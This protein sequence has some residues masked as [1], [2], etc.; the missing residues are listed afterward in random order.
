MISSPAISNTGFQAGQHLHFNILFQVQ[1]SKVWLTHM[2]VMVDTK[3]LQ[4]K[5]QSWVNTQI[6]QTLH[7]GTPKGI[8]IPPWK[9]T[10]LHIWEH[11]GHMPRANTYQGYQ[12]NRA[13]PRPTHTFSLFSWHYLANPARACAHDVALALALQKI[14]SHVSSSSH[15][16]GL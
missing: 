13:L 1:T 4:P 7:T 15:W 11:N 8:P 6:K 2:Y 16:A 14:K 3:W 10:Q 5:V 9:L 12:G